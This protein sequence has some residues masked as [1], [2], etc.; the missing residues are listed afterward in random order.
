MLHRH[1]PP[2][3]LPWRDQPGELPPAPGAVPPGAKDRKKRLE[4]DQRVQFEVRLA[5]IEMISLN[6]LPNVNESP[7]IYGSQIH[8]TLPNSGWKRIST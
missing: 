5:E 4:E 7:Q 3:S 8:M 2:R 6:S 1:L